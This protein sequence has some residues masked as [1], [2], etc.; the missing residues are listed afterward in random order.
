MQVLPRKA[1]IITQPIRGIAMS[2]SFLFQS[3]VMREKL[4][5]HVGLLGDS[6][7]VSL[8]DWRGCVRM[9]RRCFEDQVWRRV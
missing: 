8:H 9:E 5:T 2:V 7:G 1:S 6:D 3:K 4:R